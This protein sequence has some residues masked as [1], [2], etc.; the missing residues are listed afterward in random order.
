M[1]KVKLEQPVPLLLVTQTTD[2]VGDIIDAV[3]KIQQ[4]TG[5][6]YTANDLA[7]SY[8][9]QGEL[10]IGISAQQVEKVLPMIV[11]PAPIDDR[12]LT[13][14]YERIVPLLIEAIKELQ[15]QIDAINKKIDN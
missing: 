4:L 2:K 8:G 9:Y 6:Y 10:Q 13:V 12:F 14:R 15:D 11:A 1:L 5:F 7:K 3:K